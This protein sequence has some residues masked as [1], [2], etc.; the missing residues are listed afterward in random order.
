MSPLPSL[1]CSDPVS[2]AE[3][4][5]GCS[6]GS[7]LTW[8]TEL[9]SVGRV[10]VR[11]VPV[12]QG[13]WRAIADLEVAEEQR[14]FVGPTTGY[15]SLTHL[16]DQGW[17]PLAILADGEAVGFAMWTHDPSDD[18]C[19][20]GGLMIDRAQ[21]RRG[22]GRAAMEALIAMALASGARVVKLSYD[23]E[24]RAARALYERLG[25]RETGEMEGDEMVASLNLR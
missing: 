21:Q 7:S 6:E 14:R 2:V 1:S 9:A 3:R 19:W 5:L 12:G 10:G 16:G 11:I 22:H 17:A 23:P 25:F 18:A 8:A 13:N 4:R 15:L 24:N 20:I